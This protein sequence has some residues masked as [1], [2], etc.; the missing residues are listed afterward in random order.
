MKLLK[1]ALATG[2]VAIAIAILLFFLVS[3]GVLRFG[4]QAPA[5]TA[6]SPTPAPQ[7]PTK[8]VLAGGPDARYARITDGAEFAHQTRNATLATYDSL[9][10]P[11]DPWYA[12][13]RMA[14]DYYLCHLLGGDVYGEGLLTLAHAHA[15]SAYEQGCRDPLIQAICD[16]WT[17]QLC[18]RYNIRSTAAARSMENCRQLEASP[19][20]PLAKLDLATTG[21]RNA[22]AFARPDTRKFWKDDMTPFLTHPQTYFDM[23]TA[24]L[25]SVIQSGTPRP[26]AGMAFDNLVDATNASPELM[27]Q[28]NN[29]FDSVIP[30]STTPANDYAVLRGSFLV[31]WAW[32]ARGTGWANS[33]TSEGWKHMGA[34]LSMA[35]DVLEKVEDQFPGDPAIP[36]E[37][38][39]VELGQGTGRYRM[40]RLFDRAQRADPGYV[41]AYKRKMYYLQPR[42]HGSPRDILEFGNYCIEAAGWSELIPLLY[43]PALALMADQDPSIYSH[44]EAW[45]QVSSLYESFLKA[46]PE[47]TYHRTLYLRWAVKSG[48]LETAREQLSLLGPDWHRGAIK[49]WEFDELVAA[50]PQ[51]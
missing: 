10:K 27:E 7:Q 50:I 11:S 40:E 35:K 2:A 14:A 32:T 15:A 33:V 30:P 4:A 1:L 19:Y 47:S 3:N 44:P 26:I 12:D 41:T 29:R 36:A 42:W 21:V 39:R 22:L 49:E 18:G 9:N 16:V 5:A 38:I 8:R 31:S 51:A 17:Y 23:A 45:K 24:S 34:R 6:Q 43:P 48:N 46:H 13:G 20:P 37:L 25:A 28:L